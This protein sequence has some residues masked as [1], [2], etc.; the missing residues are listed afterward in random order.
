MFNTFFAPQPYIKSGIRDIGF[1]TDGLGAV[2]LRRWPK[3]DGGL[4]VTK[5]TIKGAG[6]HIHEEKSVSGH[7]EPIKN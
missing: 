5:L 7:Y 2:E 3:N 6:F 4:H 1:Y